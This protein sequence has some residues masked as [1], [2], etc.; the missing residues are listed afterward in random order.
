MQTVIR[1]APP[2][3]K[4]FLDARAAGAP[5]EKL[6]QLGDAAMAEQEAGDPTSPLASLRLPK[7]R[8]RLVWD[9]GGNNA[10]ADVGDD[11]PPD[12]AG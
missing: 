1:N 5:R 12:L 11:N 4:A 2:A 8:L 7:S 3:L 9:G 10:A 6:I